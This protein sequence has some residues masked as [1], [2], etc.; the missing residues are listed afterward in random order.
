MGEKYVTKVTFTRELGDDLHLLE[1][2]RKADPNLSWSREE[3]QKEFPAAARWSEVADKA[4][5]ILEFLDWARE[6]EGLQDVH[7]G[8]LSPQKLV[9]EFYEVDEDA[10]EADRVRLYLTLVRNRVTGGG[11]DTKEG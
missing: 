9:Y 4:A 1:E 5:L 6:G 8:S 3:F 11:R 7:D 2:R 10:L